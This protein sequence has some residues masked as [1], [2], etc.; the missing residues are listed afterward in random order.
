M[1]EAPDARTLP[2]LE[3]RDEYRSG[4]SNRLTTAVAGRR[5]SPEGG[6]PAPGAAA[7]LACAVA[8]LALA[9]CAQP[10]R[11]PVPDV[12]RELDRIAARVALLG[13]PDPALCEE[14]ACFAGVEWVTLRPGVTSCKCR[15]G[16][17]VGV[18]RLAKGRK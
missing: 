14:K 11:E 15:R 6:P 16:P 8:A 7:K 2:G 3:G 9:A 17:N 13:Q 12:A 5:D 10:A 18:H 1:I 4:D